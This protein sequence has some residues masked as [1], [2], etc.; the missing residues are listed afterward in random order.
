MCLVVG[1]V[2][3]NP[4]ILVLRIGFPYF[5]QSKNAFST[6]HK[7]HNKVFREKNSEAVQAKANATVFNGSKLSSAAQKKKKGL[8]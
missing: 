5:Q 2:N 1:Y 4:F 7:Q 8:V 6:T 3:I